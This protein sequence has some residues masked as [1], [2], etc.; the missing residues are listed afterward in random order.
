MPDVTRSTALT[1]TD[2]R[3]EGSRTGRTFFGGRSAR[4][5]RDRSRNDRL[6]RSVPRI[7]AVSAETCA[8]LRGGARSADTPPRCSLGKTGAPGQREG[9]SRA[10]H[11]DC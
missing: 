2:S 10:G 7:V 3:N 5:G 4:H 9:A 8:T 11:T 1:A 6:A